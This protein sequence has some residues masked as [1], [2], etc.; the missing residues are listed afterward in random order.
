MSTRQNNHQ[1]LPNAQRSMTS[2]WSSLVSGFAFAG[3][4]VTGISCLASMHWAADLFAQFK[5]HWAAGLFAVL[6]FLAKLKRWRVFLICL[7]CF[8]LNFI[9][10]FPYV[11]GTIGRLS[12]LSQGSQ[13]VTASER[14]AKLKLISLNVLTRNREYQ[15]VVDFL[16]AEQADFVVLLEVNAAWK[17]M[18]KPLNS[19]YEYSRFETREDNFGIAFL[20]KHAWSEIEVFE[21]MALKLPSIDATFERLN[22]SGSPGGSDSSL[23]NTVLTKPLR[24]IGTHPIP[25]LGQR[26][27]SARNEQLVN[28]AGRFD[29]E[30]NNIMAG[31]F[32]LTPW[33]PVFAD[34]LSTGN[35]RDAAI[36][37]GLEPTWYV[38]PT[39]MGGLKIDH[40]LVGPGIAVTRHRTGAEV[41]SDHR[42]VI[43]EFGFETR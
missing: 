22:L 17:T 26:E 21:S 31:D 23:K 33:S 14:P 11:S 10:V 28:V 15:S 34:M 30:S 4:V 7:V 12:G 5:L 39:W 32:N 19:T 6:I 36:E 29:S 20:S 16:N 24:I 27:S 41:G 35:L 42:A 8:V 40:V 43:V 2:W 37:F 13:A 38:F 25:P 3:I 1:E 9:P 18:L